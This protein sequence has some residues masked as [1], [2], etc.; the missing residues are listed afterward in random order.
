MPTENK[1]AF[2]WDVFIDGFPATTALATVSTQSNYTGYPKLSTSPEDGILL[3][4]L[5]TDTNGIIHWELATID[6]TR[7]FRIYASYFMNY[8]GPVIGFGGS[9]AFTSFENTANGGLALSYNCESGQTTISENG[10]AKSTYNLDPIQSVRNMVMSGV[11]EAETC[12]SRR[13]LT[14]FQGDN[15]EVCNALDITDWVPA[16]KFICF[17]GRTS[18]TNAGS[19]H[20]KDF[21]IEY[22]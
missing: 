7:D 4:P 11:L 22:I 10:V 6:F 15:K 17:G 20:L 1:L 21:R 16:G 5:V 3:N 9:Y 2:A 13:T 19:N 8:L 12:G 18:S 14:F